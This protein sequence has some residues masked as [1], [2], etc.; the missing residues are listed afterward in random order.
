MKTKTKE[1]INNSKSIYEYD[2]GKINW[3]IKL[4][5]N[6]EEIIIEVED[7]FT[8]LEIYK[9]SFNL[10]SLYEKDEKRQKLW[11]LSFLF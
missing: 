1:E 3:K 6:K 11:M 7:T 5:T 9:N 2:D 4:Y 10:S 8:M